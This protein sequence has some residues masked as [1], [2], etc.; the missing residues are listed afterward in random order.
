MS[1]FSQIEK[2][3]IQTLTWFEIFEYP[4]ALIELH[5]FLYQFSD[6]ISLS[7]LEQ[8]LDNSSI[9]KSSQGFYFL[10]TNTDIVE[11]RIAQDK[12]AQQKIKLAF[13]SAQKIFWIPGV[14]MIALCN[15]WY[16]KEE[17]DIDFFIITSP[18]RIWLTRFFVTVWLH[19]LGRRR[20]GEKIKDR[21]CLSFYISS[22]RNN[23]WTTR[24]LP[25]DP[26]FDFW[27][28]MLMPIFDRNRAYQNFLHDNK[29]LKNKFKNFYGN[30]FVLRY[31]IGQKHWLIKINKILTML[32]DTRIGRC[33]EKFF[34]YIQR[35]K[36][37]GNKKTTGSG[38]NTRVIISD[39][40]LKFH[41]NDR[42]EKYREMFYQKVTQHLDV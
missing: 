25:E 8:F 4:L 19:I 11:K 35:K 9:V 15:N 18:G 33:S 10:S 17:S 31:K 37:F 24:L 20:H 42:R 29:W 26:Y 16:F 1:D 7:E 36:I 28:A 38:N 14:E 21:V 41:E 3:I 5:K 12:I 32:F 40:M 6:K 27:T 39:N 34:R 22:N 30:E 13:E 2:S 23:L